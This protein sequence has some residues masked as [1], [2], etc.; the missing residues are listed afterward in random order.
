MIFTALKWRI[1]YLPNIKLKAYP[2][3][4]WHQIKPLEYVIS[5]VPFMYPPPTHVAV[6]VKIPTNIPIFL[7]ANITSSWNNFNDKCLDNLLIIINFLLLKSISNINST[8]LLVDPFDTRL[9]SGSPHPYC[10]NQDIK[11]Y[12]GCNSRPVNHC[13]FLEKKVL[14]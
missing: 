6:M 13:E 7:P 12:D 8:Y 2:T 10:Q 5:A 1:H 3:G 11:E 9:F 4:A 14:L